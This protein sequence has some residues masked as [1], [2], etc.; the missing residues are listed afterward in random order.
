MFSFPEKASSSRSF[1]SFFKKSMVKQNNLKMFK[2]HPHNSEW[3]DF[4]SLSVTYINENWHETVK[5]IGENKFQEGYELTLKN[6]IKNGGRYLYIYKRNYENVGL[7]NLYTDKIY[8]SPCNQEVENVLHI[9]EFYIL[10]QFRRLHYGNFLFEEIKDIGKSLNSPLLL[11][12]VDENLDVANKFWKSHFLKMTNNKGRN[13][14]W[15][16]L[17]ERY[18]K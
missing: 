5:K 6:Q 11:A 1:T 4:L 17:D 13:L 16:E 8:W 15:E 3:N 7:C 14:Y 18:E 2:I 10:P 12:E 9:A